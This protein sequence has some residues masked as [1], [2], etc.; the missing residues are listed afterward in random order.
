MKKLFLFSLLVPL[1]L[2]TTCKNGKGIFE[3]KCITQCRCD[4]GRFSFA[5]KDAKGNDYFE[6]HPN[7][8]PQNFMVYDENWNYATNLGYSWENTKKNI[9]IETPIFIDYVYSRDPYGIA[10]IKTFYI[11]L[12]QDIDTIRVEYKQKNE[13]MYMDYARF[14]YNDE[15]IVQENNMD[16]PLL[17]GPFIN[18]K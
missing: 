3:K 13:C 12:D 10:K 14:Y 11:Q 16:E 9:F 1:V 2:L 18:K 17:T 7:I 6:T 15:F 5:L 4:Y 8:S